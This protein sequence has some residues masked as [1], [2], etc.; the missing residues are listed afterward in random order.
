MVG[1]G[2]ALWDLLPTGKKVGGAP[3]NFAFHASQFGLESYAISVLGKDALGE[4]LESELKK[5]GLGLIM[6]KVDFPTGTVQVTLDDKGAPSYEICTGVAWDNIPFTPEMEELA[7][8]TSVVC[9]GSLAQRNKVSRDTITRFVASMPE[10]E[11]VLKIFD[12]NLRQN[13]YDKEVIENSLH[14]SNVLK[15]NDDEIVIVKDLLGYQIDSPA[16]IC[17]ALIRDYQLRIVI[18]TCGAHPSMVFTETEESVI[19]TPKCKI[20]DT[21]GAGDSFTGSFA[22]GILKGFPIAKAHELAVK[23]AGYVCTQPGAM[24]VYPD[25]FLDW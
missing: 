5:T 8:R 22:A 18:L 2:E 25:G 15:L 23:V 17:K 11:N 4:E 7:K 12:I 21:V 1:I 20:V 14:M 9:F 13:F 6:P 19:P 10:S 3:A 24:P 16:E